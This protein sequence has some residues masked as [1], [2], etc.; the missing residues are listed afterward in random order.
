MTELLA[1]DFQVG[2]TGALTPVARLQPV[3]VAGVIVSNATLHN[4]DEIIRKDIRIHDTVIIRRAGDVI[5]EVVSVVLAKRPANTVSI[6]MPSHC[7]VCGSIV[8]RESGQAASKCSGGLFCS[9]QLKR[10]IWHFASRKALGIEGLGPAII[11]Q[12]VDLNLIQ[13]IAD[14]FL[15]TPEQLYKLPNMGQKSAEKICAAIHKSKQT[16]L[17]RFIYALGIHD[18]GETSARMLALHFGDLEPLMQAS[19]EELMQLKDMGPVGAQSLIDFFSEPHNRDMIRQLKANGVYWPIVQKPALQ[20]DSFWQGKTAVLTGTLTS[21]SREEAKA[22]LQALG[23]HVTSSVSAKTDY[24]IAGVDAGSKLTKAQS[25]GLTILDENAL[26]NLL[27]SAA[28]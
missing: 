15:L 17:Q 25:L 28:H 3:G 27:S 22:R 18:I 9:A 7:P 16:T 12:W 14:L 10:T 24:V 26:I 5:P 11:D 6:Q 4:M 1:V 20:P 19:S 23:A 21:L 2:R 13:T 8:V